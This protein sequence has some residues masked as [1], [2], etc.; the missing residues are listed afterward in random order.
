MREML[1]I[2]LMSGIAV[3]AI[4]SILIRQCSGHDL[5][6][7]VT[8]LDQS[9][10]THTLFT[11]CEATKPTPLASRFARALCRLCWALRRI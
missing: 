4:D 2:R 11:T 5:D 1:S 8:E 3:L 10:I 6:M 7:M 9:A